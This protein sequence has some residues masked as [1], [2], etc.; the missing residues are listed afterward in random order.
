[1]SNQHNLLDFRGQ[2]FFIG[3]DVHKK[4]W[5]TTI[6][7]NHVVLKTFRMNPSAK[8]L[9]SYM[10]R[11]Y[12]GG[13]YHSVYE[14]GFCGFSIHRQ[15]SKLG[16]DNMVINP[17]DVPTMNKEKVTKRDKPDSRKLARELENCSLEAIYVPDEFHEQLRGL[18][19]YR[20]KLVKRQTQMK[21]RIK[22]YLHLYDVRIPVSDE[23]SHWSGAF[24]NWLENLEFSYSFGKDYL[25]FSIEELKEVRSRLADVTRLLRGYVKEHSNLN[26]IIRQYIASVP[27][28]GFITA[29]TFYSEIIDIGR[30]L[31]L[32][33]LCSFVG[34]V[35]S[36]SSSDDNEKLRGLTPRRNRYL[37]YLIIEAAWV[38][39][40][41]DPALT[42]AFNELT[43][44]MK[45]QDAIIRI[46]K[47]L[48]NR[49]R[50][51]WKHKSTYN[52][53][54]IQ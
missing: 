5:T 29:L 15:L 48:L 42:L 18:V 26:K 10:N 47:K 30:F 20:Y 24:I 33:N 8:E 43:K 41:V 46:A 50:Y 3:L 21:N 9:W 52:P 6:R 17:A 53:G 28:V 36:V 2:D 54:L 31:K 34:L 44:R 51:V 49:I 13:N 19:R 12:P 25:R 40:R 35:P 23:M 38:A 32:D 39:V 37:R 4:S 45:K 16:I 7:V 27:G 14:A 1:M 11:H 22:S